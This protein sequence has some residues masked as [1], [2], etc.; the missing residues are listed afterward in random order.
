[1][2]IIK[3]KT[4]RKTTA[5]SKKWSSIPPFKGTEDEISSPPY[6]KS[7]MYKSKQCPLNILSDFWVGTMRM[8]SVV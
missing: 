5:V 4:S 1:M 3:L 6:L 8:F 7:K 2:Q